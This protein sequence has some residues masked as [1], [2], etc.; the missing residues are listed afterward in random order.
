MHMMLDV[1]AIDPRDDDYQST[2]CCI[3]VFVA[4]GDDKKPTAV[5]RWI[6]ETD[7]DKALADAAVRLM[8]SNRAIQQ[9]T[10]PA[11]DADYE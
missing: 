9:D 3:M 1:S 2:T 11:I 4:V 7:N 6:A 8:N 10:R 5:Q